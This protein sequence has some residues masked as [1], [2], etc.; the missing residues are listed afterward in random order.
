MDLRRL[1]EDGMTAARRDML[2][3]ALAVMETIDL[4]EARVADSGIPYR[5]VRLVGAAAEGRPDLREAVHLRIHGDR[6]PAAWLEELSV[7]EPL[8]ERRFTSE[9]RYGR[10]SGFE[11][12]I[13]GTAVRAHRCPVDQVPLEDRHLF[14]GVGIPVATLAMVRRLADDTPRS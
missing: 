3:S 11:L 1:G 5:G 13:D 6:S 10:L 8:D 9:T 7:L 12:N 2:E 14:T 4:L